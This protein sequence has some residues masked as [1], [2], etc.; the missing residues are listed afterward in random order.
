MSVLAKQRT[1]L[2][3]GCCWS[4]RGTGATRCSGDMSKQHNSAAAAAAAAAPITRKQRKRGGGEE[5]NEREKKRGEKRN[6]LFRLAAPVNPLSLSLIIRSRWN[7]MSICPVHRHPDHLRLV[8]YY[9]I[10]ALCVCVCA[11]VNNTFV[12][13]SLINLWLSKSVKRG[14]QQVTSFVSTLEWRLDKN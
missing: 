1:Q 9:T 13:Q 4:G 7:Q 10:C 8:L 6:R 5:E 2:L 12:S 11:Q 14:H 3:D